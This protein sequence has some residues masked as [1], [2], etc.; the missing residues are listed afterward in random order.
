MG[1]AQA[2]ALLLAARAGMP[3]HRYAP[4]QVKHAV[5]G[6]GAGSKAQVQ[7]TVRLLL[8]LGDEQMSEDAS[9]ALAVALCHEQSWRVAARVQV[10]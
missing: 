8:R 4:A 5:A 9:D 2:V 7:R 3:I 1:Q 6:Y 10:R